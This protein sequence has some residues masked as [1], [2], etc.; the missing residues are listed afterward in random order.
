[1][2]LDDIIRA[3]QAGEPDTLD[4]LETLLGQS[5]ATGWDYYDSSI[6]DPIDAIEQA[7]LESIH[8][9]HSTGHFAG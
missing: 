3:W 4:A 1:M 7:A 9:R 5:D 2:S 6:T 8:A